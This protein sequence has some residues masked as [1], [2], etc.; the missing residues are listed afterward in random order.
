MCLPELGDFGGGPMNQN[1]SEDRQEALSRVEALSR[2]RAN[3]GG[4]TCG[5]RVTRRWQRRTIWRN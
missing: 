3:D 1:E 5:D 4:S 2:G